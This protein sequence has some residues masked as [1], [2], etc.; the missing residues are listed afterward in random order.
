VQGKGAG[1]WKIAQNAGQT[2]HFG[3][4]DTT[5][6]ATGYLASTNRYDSI[7]LLCITANTDWAIMTTQGV[8]TYN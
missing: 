3:N 2:I 4:V 1:G 6:G 7:Q 5:T 8:V